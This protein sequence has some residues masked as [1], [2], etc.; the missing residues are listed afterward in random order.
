MNNSHRR[1]TAKQ[2]KP[3]VTNVITKLHLLGLKQLRE[4]REI[5]QLYTPSRAHPRMAVTSPTGAKFTPL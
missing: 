5:N 2:L 1:A 3:T 4:I